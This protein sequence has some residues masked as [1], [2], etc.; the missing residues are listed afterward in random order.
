ML[1]GNISVVSWPECGEIDIMEYLGHETNK[2][3]GT[4]HWE[5]I[6]H[7]YLGSNTVLT[8]GNFHEDFHIFTLTWT[9]NRF[10]WSVDNQQYFELLRSTIPLFPFDLPEFFICNVAVGGNWPGPPDETTTFP[11]HM[12]VDYIRV[13]Q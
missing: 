5:D 9:P 3:Y 1:G 12:I 4:V 11:Q 13:Y 2:V 7:K 6:G 8:P 10:S